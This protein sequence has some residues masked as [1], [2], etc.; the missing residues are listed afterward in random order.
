[1]RAC[2]LDR[3]LQDQTSFYISYR[4]LISTMHTSGFLLFASFTSS[5]GCCHVAARGGHGMAT[6]FPTILGPKEG[7]SAW[8]HRQRIL[9]HPI[10][11]MN[12]FSA[13]RKKNSASSTTPPPPHCPSPPPTSRHR[14]RLPPSPAPPLQ[15]QL[16]L[17]ILPN[18]ASLHAARCGAAPVAPSPPT[19]ATG[20][21]PAL[22]ALQRAERDGAGWPSR[23]VA[24][25]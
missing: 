5:G 13:R 24:V 9:G 16:A 3:K 25:M 4:T 10:G 19:G 21:R 17:P 11:Q 20:C 14:S 18:A 8:P 23:K 1:M 7:Q 15:Q 6:S 12:G 22:H 2:N